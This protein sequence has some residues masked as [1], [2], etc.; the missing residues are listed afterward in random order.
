M[1]FKNQC[2]LYGF[3]DLEEASRG[4]SPD[5]PRE[6]GPKLQLQ[7]PFHTCRAQDYGS[8]NKLSKYQIGTN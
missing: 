1:M 4:S 7:A 8:L 5:Y 6:T 2:F 3:L